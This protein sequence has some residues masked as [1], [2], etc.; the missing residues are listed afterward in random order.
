MQVYS[1]SQQMIN[2]Q[3]F[4]NTSLTYLNMG[5]DI[6]FLIIFQLTYVNP[7]F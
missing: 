4:Q 5:I 2:N 3:M 6:P 7:I 1:L